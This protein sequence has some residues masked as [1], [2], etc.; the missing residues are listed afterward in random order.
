MEANPNRMQ[1]LWGRRPAWL[2][3]LPKF[4]ARYLLLLLPLLLP[5]WLFRDTNF[6]MLRAESGYYLMISHS[7]PP[8]LEAFV[9]GLFR[10]SYNGHYIP[11]ALVS[12]LFLS[13]IF[14]ANETLWKYRQLFLASLLALSMVAAFLYASLAAFSSRIVRWSLSLAITVVF[15]AMP[16]MTDFVPWPFMGLQ[17]V[18]MICTALSLALL[19]KNIYRF[20]L[21]SLWAAAMV[22]YLSM[23]FTGVG[24]AA[25][26][27]MATCLA[28]L[29][30][31]AALGSATL[32]PHL[33][34]YIQALVAIIIF[35][36]AH[37]AAMILLAPPGSAVDKNAVA[38]IGLRLTLARFGGFVSALPPAMWR[39]FWGPEGFPL[40]KVDAMYSDAL[41]GW[42][43]IAVGVLIAVGFF[44][45]FRRSPTQRGLIQLLLYAF[46]FVGL[47]VI[48]AMILSRY[49]HDPDTAGL[50][51]FLMGARYIIL[52]NFFATILIFAIL[53]SFNFNRALIT[54]VACTIV[55]FAAIESQRSYQW[56]ILREIVPISKI[57][58]QRCWNLARNVIAE[59]RNAQ[60]PILD[61]SLKA[62]CNEYDGTI[63]FFEPLFRQEL[64][65]PVSEK[66]TWIA[67]VGMP[68][69]RL[70]VYDQVAPSIRALRTQLNVDTTGDDIRLIG[71]PSTE[72][73]DAKVPPNLGVAISAAGRERQSVWSNPPAQVIY[74]GVKLSTNPVFHAYLSIHMQIWKDMRSDGAEFQVLVSQAGHTQIVLDQFINPSHDASQRRWN[75]VEADL[76][77]YRNQTVDLVLRALPGPKNDEYGDWCIWGDP[78]I[79]QR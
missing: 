20:S 79:V 33:K 78:R 54:A 52:F 15:I 74:H 59:C 28:I 36:V 37:S 77:E 34:S 2:S 44:I 11:L 14:G 56:G 72:V 12:E 24:L 13:K 16:V 71:W 39:Q 10:Y 53:M 7:R 31:L 51:A 75:E 17:M 32:K 35:T 67:E 46:S 73:K 40:P 1:R 60:L 27:G 9:H 50:A 42:G 23:H 57:S 4:E 5:W 21:P 69:D 68:P 43:F 62:A 6:E 29:A 22:C 58:H 61:I 55:S 18:M 19:L 8:V 65:I 25:A 26:A 3:R 48:V 45:S 63:Q 66:L 49:A 76:K 64:G 47:L 41:Y 70:A 30:V 38:S